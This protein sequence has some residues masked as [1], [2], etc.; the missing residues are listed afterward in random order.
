M[1]QNNKTVIS[2]PEDRVSWV[3]LKESVSRLDSSG[4]QMKIMSGYNYYLNPNQRY[5]VQRDTKKRELCR[6]EKKTN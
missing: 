2:S 3:C 4:K 1:Y 5:H 6:L